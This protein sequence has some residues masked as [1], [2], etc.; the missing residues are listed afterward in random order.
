METLEALGY[1]HRLPSAFGPRW[2]IL[3]KGKEA[4]ANG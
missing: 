1:A 4:L 2:V 3:D